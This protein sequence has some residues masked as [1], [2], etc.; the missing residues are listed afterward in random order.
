MS[1]HSI[2]YNFALNL[3]NTVVGL[4]FPVVTFP[5]ASRI[6]DPDGIGLVS[7]YKSVVC[8]ISMLT[9]VGIPIYA[10]RKIAQIRSDERQRNQVTAEILTLSV[11]LGIFGYIIVAVLAATSKQI[12]ENL[13]LFLLISSTIG[14]T[15]IGVSWFYQAVE[16]FKFITIRSL[17]VRTLSAIALFV[18]VRDKSDLMSYAAIIV[19]AEVGNY[20]FNFLRL[21]S[22]FKGKGADLKNMKVFNH[23]K[24]SLKLFPIAVIISIYVQLDTIMLG[25]LS[26]ESSVGYY[27][28]CHGLTNAIIGIVTSLGAVL[29]PRLAH[30]AS[31][32]DW[33]NFKKVE[34]KAYDFIITICLPISAGLLIIAPELIPIFSGD[35]F[36]PA[37]TTLRIMSPI[38]IFISLSSLTGMQILYSQGK[39]NCVIIA[40]SAGAILNFTLNLLLIPRMSQ[41]GAAISTCIAEAGVLLTMICAGRKYIHY[42]PSSKNILQ[43]IIFTAIM[44]ICVT[45]I[46]NFA[47]A[48]LSLAWLFIAEVLTGIIIYAVLLIV[49]KNEYML[50]MIEHVRSKLK[51]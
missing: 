36:M 33:E 1:G 19:I 47:A 40:T 6:L 26:S 31:T 4:L 17:I 42:S 14:F 50:M 10:V 39:E 51:I 49:S 44:A 11:I 29:L 46:H 22:Y 20:F 5:Y 12:N 8:Y 37:I 30:I 3:A 15:I 16:D 9:A 48:C 38:V 23:L 28:A 34:K 7:F 43:A 35:K 32:G 2:K 24:P 25:F 27:T 13:P 21:F 45:L 41:N 18:F